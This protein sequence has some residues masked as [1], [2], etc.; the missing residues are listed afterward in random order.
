MMLYYCVIEFLVCKFKFSR[1]FNTAQLSWLLIKKSVKSV[2]LIDNFNYYSKSS[3][4]T[5]CEPNIKKFLI[6]FILHIYVLVSLLTV[7]TIYVWDLLYEI[8]KLYLLL[9]NIVHKNCSQK[10]YHIKPCYTSILQKKINMKIVNE[11]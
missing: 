3:I 10:N 4:K 9:E 6:I 7:L 11:I 1:Y 5:P 2:F 8:I